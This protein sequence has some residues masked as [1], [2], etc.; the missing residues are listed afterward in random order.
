MTAS[1]AISCKLSTPVLGIAFVLS[2]SGCATPEPAQPS[3]TPVE[4]SIVTVTPRAVTVAD[5]LPGRV[6]AFRVAEIR[7]QVSG[8]IRRRLFEQGSEVRAGQPL[9]EIDAAPFR[10]EVATAAAVLQR[11]EAVLAR[12]RTQVERLRPLVAED[13]ISRQSYDDTVAAQ[14]QAAADVAQSRATLARRRLDVGFATIRAP[15]AGR[16]DQSVVTEGALATAGD[17][18]ALATVQQIDSVYVDVRQ[19]ASRLDQLREAT[20]TGAGVRTA[21]VTILSANGRAYA[22]A[23]RMLF[24]GISVDPGTGEVVA[25]VR[26]ANPGRLLLPGM[27]VRARLPRI[28]RADALSV[29]AQAIGHDAAGSATVGVVDRQDRVHTRIVETG[30]TVE[31]AI[32]ILRG[33]RAGD[34]IVVEGGDRVRP[35]E[36]VTTVAWRT[37][38]TALAQR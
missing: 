8:I 21:P 36:P 14:T 13:A 34:R 29:P 28:V 26:A 38:A 32:I 19:P 33:V 37:P 25:R 18:T 9:F 15:I 16:I 24:S 27:F 20:R 6:V 35:G 5:E 11:A 2:L 30:D 12:G 1:L 10:A 3:A 31:G 23:G 7:P 17:A 4:V 22:V